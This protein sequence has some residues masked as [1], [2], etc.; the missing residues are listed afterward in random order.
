MTSKP[1]ACEPCRDEPGARSPRRARRP[2]SGG[3]ARDEEPPPARI[4]A[5]REDGADPVVASGRAARRARAHG[6]LGRTSRFYPGT[7]GLADD[8]ERIAASLAEDGA[9]TGVLATEPASGRRIYVCAFEEPDGSRSWLALDPD[10]RPDRRSARGARCGLDRGAVRGRRGGSVPGR[11]RRASL[12]AR[13]PA[14][15]G[16]SGGDRGGGAGCARASSTCSGTPPQLATPSR[17]DEIG[18]AARQ[19]ERALDP[20][21]PSPFTTAMR[22][23]AAVADALWEDVQSA[24]RG[25]LT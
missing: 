18:D 25:P 9:V 19:L 14:D 1:R 17:L 4:L 21:A 10:G 22:S 2:P 15:L 8:L 16:G 23:A 24:Y 6:R 12:P 3:Q 5:E 20:T 7:V 11:S 13:R